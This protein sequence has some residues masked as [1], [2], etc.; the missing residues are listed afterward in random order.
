MKDYIIQNNAIRFKCSCLYPPIIPLTPIGDNRYW[1]RKEPEVC[2][3]HTGL[4][5]LQKDDVI[6]VKDG[7]YQC[8]GKMGETCTICEECANPIPPFQG[9]PLL[10]RMLCKDCHVKMMARIHT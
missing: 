5:I 2:Q 9:D 3:K 4:H 6:V 1:I 8:R 7:S 10:G